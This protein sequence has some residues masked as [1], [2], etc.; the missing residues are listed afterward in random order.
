MLPHATGSPETWRIHR[1][2]QVTPGGHAHTQ[3]HTFFKVNYSEL[4]Y[5]C[6]TLVEVSI[7]ERNFEYKM[8]I[9]KLRRH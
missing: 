9:E 7:Y 4:H 5:D 3:T 2:R 8:K 6:E 1:S